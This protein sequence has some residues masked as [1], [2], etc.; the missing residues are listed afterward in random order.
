[1]IMLSELSG[2]LSSVPP[3]VSVH[4][5]GCGNEENPELKRGWDW[6]LDHERRSMQTR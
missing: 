4:F 6:D 2:E 5:G 3:S 1:M